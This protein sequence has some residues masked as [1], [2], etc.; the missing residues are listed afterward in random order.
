MVAVCEAEVSCVGGVTGSGSDEVV[1]WV[2]LTGA[3]AGAVEAGV[4]MVRV[5]DR[6]EGAS[7]LR[8]VIRS[9]ILKP[10]GCLLAG[11]VSLFS[12]HSDV[13]VVA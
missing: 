5:F 3:P 13:S 12:E 11:G 4:G 8:V 9:A 7:V 2:W 6:R 1:V 10:S